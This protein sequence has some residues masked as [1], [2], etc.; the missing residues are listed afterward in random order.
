MAALLAK[1][2]V[3]TPSGITRPFTFSSSA[4]VAS[5]HSLIIAGDEYTLRLNSKD[6]TTGLHSNVV[7]CSTD[8]K[9][10]Q[11]APAV[12]QLFL[13]H[14]PAAPVVVLKK[15][16]EPA[17]LV[18]CSRDEGTLCFQTSAKGAPES[19]Y[20]KMLMDFNIRV[21]I[22]PKENSGI[23]DG[24]FKAS[25]TALQDWTQRTPTSSGSIPV[26]VQM[27]IIQDMYK[28]LTTKMEECMLAIRRV[29]G[30]AHVTYDS[31]HPETQDALAAVK[32][33]TRSVAPGLHP[34]TVDRNT[35][36]TMIKNWNAYVACVESLDTPA[37]S[38][39]RPTERTLRKWKAGDFSRRA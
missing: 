15:F 27:S 18:V 29:S 3:L 24:L 2:F 1:R 14:Y 11:S 17:T 4:N 38:H 6:N 8:T 35:L 5:I 26:E 32:S 23:P 7:V 22:L 36:K 20:L 9:Q 28:T 10:V 19:N 31:L 33:G 13:T 39:A 21:C 16:A 25:H 34:H 30:A 37:V 12:R